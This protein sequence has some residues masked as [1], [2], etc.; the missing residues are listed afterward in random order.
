MCMCMYMRTYIYICIYI[1]IHAHCRHLTQFPRLNRAFKGISKEDKDVVL[2]CYKTV[3]SNT[4][5]LA[6]P[7]GPGGL[8]SSERLVGMISTY[9]GTSPTLR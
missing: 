9:P 4:L 5:L 1:Y 2:I 6:F 8:G 3:R 7:M